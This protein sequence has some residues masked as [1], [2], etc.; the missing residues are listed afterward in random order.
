MGR[1]SPFGAD[2]KVAFVERSQVSLL[3]RAITSDV[4]SARQGVFRAARIN[5]RRLDSSSGAA[6]GLPR[7]AVVAPGFTADAMMD[8][9]QPRRVIALFD[10]A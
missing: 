3:G 1:S 6:L 9:E 7:K 2:M 5:P 8:D 4:N 10:F